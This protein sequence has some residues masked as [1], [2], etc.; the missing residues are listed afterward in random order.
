MA[1][2]PPFPPLLARPVIGPRVRPVA[3]HWSG[4]PPRLGG[5]PRAGQIHSIA[6]L[7]A[8]RSCQ[9]FSLVLDILRSPS[10]L[11]LSHV[12][13]A[14]S[15]WIT[16]HVVLSENCVVKSENKFGSA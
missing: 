4:G 12:D 7:A 13:V 11:Q 3:H 15:F 9:R 5:Q 1:D 14:L 6:G 16:C 2:P 10:S 8:V